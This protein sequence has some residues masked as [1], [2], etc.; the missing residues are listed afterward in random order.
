MSKTFEGNV[1][2]PNSLFMANRE[3]R[4]SLLAMV[5]FEGDSYHGGLRSVSEYARFLGCTRPRIRNLMA[6]WKATGAKPSDRPGIDQTSTT[7][8]AGEVQESQKVAARE[9]APPTAHRPNVGQA[10]ASPSIY[11]HTH[12]QLQSTDTSLR[13]VDGHCARSGTKPGLTERA[14]SL[15]PLLVAEAAKSGK[16]WSA[17]PGKRQ[18]A[19]V[20]QRVRDA[21][22]DAC[23]QAVRG[24]RAKVDKTAR[25]GGDWDGMTYFSVTSIFRPCNFDSNVDAGEQRV[26]VDTSRQRHQEFLKSRERAM[27]ERAVEQAAKGGLQ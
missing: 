11:L 26:V 21:G 13:D 19:I 5:L 12:T 27:A 6:I 17:T 20:V 4:N 24:Y 16:V 18:L 14:R 7:P 1:R 9:E 10:S 23:I 15:W 2:I 22:E 8:P 25:S 3:D